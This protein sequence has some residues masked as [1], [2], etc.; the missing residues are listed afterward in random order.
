VF[1]KIFFFIPTVLILS[2]AKPQYVSETTSQDL[3][4]TSKESKMDCSIAFSKSAVCI[5]WYWESKPTDSDMGGFI[6]KTFRLNSFDQT[7]VEVD[8]TQIPEVIL[9]MPSMM[10]GSTPTKTSRL[11]AGTYRVSNVF[12]IMPGE[13]EIKFQIKN[14]TEISD[15]ATI[16]LTL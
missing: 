13:W 12:F 14:G 2:C 9:W 15:E 11:D 16:R 7:P 4:A 1:G 3:I 5:T 6:F 10:H 8:T